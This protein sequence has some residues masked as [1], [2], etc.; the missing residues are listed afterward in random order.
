M[1]KYTWLLFTFIAG[2][3]GCTKKPKP[4][5][6]SPFA[7]DYLT[8]DSLFRLGKDSAF[9]YFNKVA[10]Q[11]PDTLDKA[12][13]F[14][15]MAAMLY[16]AGDYFGSQELVTESLKLLDERNPGHN[17]FFAANYSLLG[18]INIEQ[19]N[20]AAGVDYT[21][22]ALAFMAPGQSAANALNNLAVA[23]QKQK[24]YDKAITIFQQLIDTVKHD[25]IIYARVLSNLARTKWL[26]NPAYNAAPEL[27]T[28][29]KLR[30]LKNEKRG[31]NASYIHL[32]DYYE[33]IHPDSS[34]LFAKKMLAVAPAPDDSLEAI[35]KIIR[36][37]SPEDARTYFPLYHSLNDSLKQAQSNSKNQYSAIR[38]ET[39]KNKADNL[40]LQQRI[41]KQRVIMVAGFALS[42]LFLVLLISWYKR[43][44]QKVELESQNRI[45]EN[46]LRTSKKVHDVVANGLYRIMT[47]LEHT[48]A[49]DKEPLLDEIE[50]LYEQ[51]RDISYDPPV[52]KAGDYAGRIHRLLSDFGT[53]G[54]RILIAGNQEKSWNGINDNLR[55]ELEYVL[56]ELMVNMS[57][58]S[59]ARNVLIRF[60]REAEQLHLLYKDDGIG[61]LPGFHMG[62]GL[63]NT[64]TRIKNLGGSISFDGQS[65]LKVEIFLPTGY[66]ND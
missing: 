48:D 26:Q 28:A 12:R 59:Q 56:Q 31:L 10:T 8:G 40:R 1:K 3:Y 18:Q 58:H 13:G 2:Y 46:Q 21:K 57:K 16:N 44:K 63:R 19:K 15:R 22:K 55:T 33:R 11:S 52:H 6:A 62:N 54:T 45:R 4:A 34:L 53:A 36:V 43:R 24:E 30:E 17:G 29:L 47:N 23:Y 14:N 51:S 60:K 25:T 38:F 61:F 32:S 49:V 27:M 39:E 20:F 35:H 7:K 64:E 66:A 5:T 50:N 9:Y 37:G 42:V 41:L 65:G